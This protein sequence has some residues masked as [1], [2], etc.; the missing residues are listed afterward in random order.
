MGNQS[1]GINLLWGGENYHKHSVIWMKSTTLIQWLQKS[2]VKLW[3]ANATISICIPFHVIS[4]LIIVGASLNKPHPRQVY[5]CLI[6]M[7]RYERYHILQFLLAQTSPSDD[8]NIVFMI[9]I[10][11]MIRSIITPLRVKA[12]LLCPPHI[13]T[14]PTQGS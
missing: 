8:Y 4:E 12:I 9:L 10:I 6:E 11:E 7:N 14:L 13:H 1:T 5:S 2:A 3:G